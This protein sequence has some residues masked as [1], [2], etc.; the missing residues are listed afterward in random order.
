[1]EKYITIAERKRAIDDNNNE[2][3]DEAYCHIVA[4]SPS[5]IETIIKLVK[6]MLSIIASTA[7]CERVF[8]EMKVLKG[9]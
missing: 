1:M 7:Q 3:S 4:N 9:R 6:I 2:S 5:R 8:S